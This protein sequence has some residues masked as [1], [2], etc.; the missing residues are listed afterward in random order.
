[1]NKIVLILVGLFMFVFFGS[2]FS[3]P[4]YKIEGEIRGLT[5]E[6]DVFVYILTEKVWDQKEKEFPAQ[7]VIPSSEVLNNQAHYAFNKEKGDYCIFVFEDIDNNKKVTHG[8]FGPAEPI[9]FYKSA[10][11]FFGPPSSKDFKFTL[12]RNI[13]SADI[14]LLYSKVHMKQ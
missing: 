3:D 2:S 8:L 14:N 10:K 4:L 7:L 11:P 12:D 5:G 6:K 9:G 13:E 1:M